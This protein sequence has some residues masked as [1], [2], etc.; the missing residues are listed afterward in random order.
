MFL[1]FLFLRLF[2]C[3]VAAAAAAV[4]L[5]RLSYAGSLEVLFQLTFLFSFISSNYFKIFLDFF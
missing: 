3:F 1:W 2:V 4:F 5:G